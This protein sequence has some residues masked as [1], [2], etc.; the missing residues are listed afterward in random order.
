[1]RLH[2]LSKRDVGAVTR[3]SG[4]RGIRASLVICSVV[5]VLWIAPPASASDG[6]P[7]PVGGV[8]LGS[9]VKP[10]D[11]GSRRDALVARERQIGRT[12]AID[13]QY[14]RWDSPIPTTHEVWTADA[15][16]IPFVTWN[17]RRGNGSVVT[18]ARIASGTEDPWIVSRADAFRTFGRP[19]YLSFHHEP[20]NDVPTFG[21]PSDYVAAFRH[22]VEVF[23]QRGA[24][25]VTFVWT[26]MAWSFERGASVA[27]QYYP[28]DSYVDVVAADGYNWYPG[29]K[30]SRWRSFQE[31]M[32]ATH[33]FA[34]IHGKPFMAA[35]YG[36]QEDPAIPGRKGNWFR[37]ILSV[38]DAWPQLIALVYFD[39]D[40]SYPWMPDTSASA[41]AGYR[42]LAS[43]PRTAAMLGSGGQGTSVSGRSSTEILRRNSFEGGVAGRPITLSGSGGSSGDAFD[44][45]V[46]RGDASLLFDDA[47]PVGSLS[48]KHSFTTTSA[49]YYVWDV[50]VPEGSRWY[51][52]VYLRATELPA[53][54]V[55]L[56]RARSSGVLRMAL[57]LLPSGALRMVDGG[58]VEVVL[59]EGAIPTDTWVRVEWGVDHSSGEAWLEIYDGSSDQRLLSAAGAAPSLV[60]RG[61]DQVRIGGQVGRRV[62]SFVLHTDEPA[63]SL[64]GPVGT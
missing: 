20:E 5:S 27:S 1:M 35:E 50:A 63:L 13:H 32:R 12:Y 44:A 46:L 11:G 60:G 58:G 24:T 26:M 34:V 55:R 37:E 8:Y 16:R 23:R 59:T 56:A 33:D 62:A 7:M 43:S 19:V 22:I 30:A 25:N 42:D 15:G 17:A 57:D 10:L 29:R 31:V 4:A 47:A 52:R 41:L 51:G 48:A 3:A 54:R 9:W 40:R 36:V 53:G 39:S 45:L 21:Q 14:Y 28:G 64:V 18:W 2:R 61:I 38:I 6:V 49:S